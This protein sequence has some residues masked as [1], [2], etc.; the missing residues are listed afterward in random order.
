[1]ALKIVSPSAGN[2]EAGETQIPPAN[3]TDKLPLTNLAL[4]RQECWELKE[5]GKSLL[6]Y[7]DKIESFL[8]DYVE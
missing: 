4:L 7:K 1:M 6:A 8:L 5:C 3:G 2:V